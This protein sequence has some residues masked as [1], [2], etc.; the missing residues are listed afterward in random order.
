VCPE[1]GPSPALGY[2][3]SKN[4][5]AVSELPG[6]LCPLL[7]SSGLSVPELQSPKPMRGPLLD[8]R[9]VALEDG[10]GLSELLGFSPVSPEFSGGSASSSVIPDLVSLASQPEPNSGFALS[11]LGMETNLAVV[12]S[13]MHAEGELVVEAGS[14]PSDLL[15]APD[16]S[17]LISSL[18]SGPL[19]H[20]SSSG[21]RVGNGLDIVPVSE[22]EE[23]FCRGIPSKQKGSK[24]L[25]SV[26]AQSVLSSVFVE[27]GVGDEV[28]GL[29]PISIL[30]LAVE[31]DSRIAVRLCL[32]D[33]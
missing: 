18:V 19:S 27:G 30:P 17:P 21:L 15:V 22:E 24:E 2:G 25:F 5:L 13:S 4:I 12:D 23:V 6:G 31:M 20:K 28:K 29:G 7:L 33:G 10:V 16:S 3:G 9:A 1:E 26:V 32:L 8:F 11:V 14:H